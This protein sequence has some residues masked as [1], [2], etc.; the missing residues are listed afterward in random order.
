MNKC[1]VIV[2]HFNELAN[3]AD[4]VFRFKKGELQAMVK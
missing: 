4:V 1:V 3:Q 2:T